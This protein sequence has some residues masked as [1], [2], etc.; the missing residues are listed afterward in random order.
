MEPGTV[1]KIYRKGLPGTPNGD[2][3]NE[4]IQAAKAAEALLET[5]L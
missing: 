4:I 2:K 3:V 1:G 5:M